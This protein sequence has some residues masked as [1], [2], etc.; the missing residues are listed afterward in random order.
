[1]TGTTNAPNCT[2]TSQNFNYLNLNANCAV[3]KAAQIGS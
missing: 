2:G 3:S 1:M